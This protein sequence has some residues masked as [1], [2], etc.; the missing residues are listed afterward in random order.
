MMRRAQKRKTRRQ[1]DPEFDRRIGR[2]LRG[3]RL[4]LGWSQQRLADRLGLTFQQVQKYEN[5]RNQISA[6]RLQQICEVV[7]VPVTYFWHAKHDPRPLARI[8]YALARAVAEIPALR[9]KQALL[10]LARE[11]ARSLSTAAG[12]DKS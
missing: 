11:C 6:A 7:E 1:I 10:R 12:R 9:P 8:D 3:R 5:G 2:L 4:E